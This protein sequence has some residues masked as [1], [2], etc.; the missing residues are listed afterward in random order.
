[1]S[2][3]LA[4]VYAPPRFVTGFSQSVDVEEL[5]AE[6]SREYHNM[7]W[8]LLSEAT[9]CGVGGDDGGGDGGGVLVSAHEVS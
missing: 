4:G 9:V 2:Y 3:L 5:N 8:V 6:L 1:M 7:H